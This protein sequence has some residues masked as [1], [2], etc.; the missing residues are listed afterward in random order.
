MNKQA[1][2]D[3][4][5]IVLKDYIPSNHFRTILPEAKTIPHGRNEISVTIEFSKESVFFKSVLPRYFIGMMYVYGFVHD[6]ENL[7]K[8]FTG[9]MADEYKKR[10]ISLYE[11]SEKFLIVFENGSKTLE[12][13]FFVTVEDV[14]SLIRNCLHPTEK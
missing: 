8:I 1:Y 12:K 9:P 4:E 6:N 14:W 2:S 11:W 7:S 5:Y 10:Q 13:Q 3:I